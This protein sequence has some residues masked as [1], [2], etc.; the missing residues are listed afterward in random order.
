MQYQPLVKDLRA[1]PEEG[2]PEFPVVELRD[3]Q[4]AAVEAGIKLGRGVFDMPPRSG[5]T[6]V[7]CELH[8]R[9]SLPTIWIAPTDRI[10]Q[11][12]ARVIEGHFGKHYVIHQIGQKGLE[13]AARHKVV[14][15]TANTAAVLP[16]E[17]YAT[18]QMIAVDEWH[19]GA[20]KTY[21]HEIFPKC[22]HV[23]F[24]YGMTGTF[25]R[26][27]GDDMA[28]HG[29]LSDTI[30]K[31]TSHELLSRGFLVPTHVAFLPIPAKPKLRGAG[32]S[33]NGGFG[34]AGIHEHTYRNQL[35]AHAALLLHQMGRKVLILV[36][37]KVQGRELSHIL[38]HFLPE[39]P[40]G[41][42]FK[43]VEFLS[44]DRDR[45]IQTQVIDSFLANQ[46]V[47]ILLGTSLL[48]EGVDLP[49][50]DALVYARGEKAEVSLTQNA[51]R[52]CT[53]IHGKPNAI[54]VDFADRHHRRLMEHSQERLA[55]YY[56]EPTFSVS[57]LDEV[58]QLAGWVE[59]LGQKA[60]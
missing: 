52:V 11:Q 44:T 13:D 27:G 33:F 50:V 6:R 29:V 56:H 38:H 36:G 19:H 24:R 8:R 43:A 46:E 9:I 39:A 20:A 48:G 34:K 15:C 2:F 12:T 40:A 16:A 25:F 31:V 49:D 30:Y 3:Y 53:A 7:M 1:R 42:Q 51:Y 18:R 21:T 14:V 17:F 28:M 22:D 5:K 32:S 4:E 10:V 57:I 58:G 60:A 23:F 37:T 47:K 54:I 35:A 55:V 41:C 26:S 45:Y 59:N